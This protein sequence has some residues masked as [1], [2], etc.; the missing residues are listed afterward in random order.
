MNDR[1]PTSRVARGSKIGK[2]A[3]GQALRNAGTRASMLGRSDEAKARI[4][5][6]A[7]LQAADQLVTV[8]GSMKGAAMKIGQMLSVIDLDLVPESHREHFQR[9]LAVLRD[10]A[11]KVSFDAMRKIIEDDLGRSISDVF[12]EFDDVPIAAASIGQVYRAQLHDGRLVAVKVQYPGIDV[13]IR[14]DMKNLA[15]FLKFW[16]STI[17]TV[18]APELAREIKLN[19]ESELD[20]EREARTQH[21][22]AQLFAGHP[23]IEVP[24]SV[25][26]ASGRRV[27]VT[28]LFDGQPF[29]A[30][31]ALPQQDRDR[32][33]EIIYRFYI[34]SMFSYSEFCGD[35]HPGNILL[36]TDGK[37]GF[38]DFGLYNKMDPVHVDFEKQCLRAA[39]ENRSQDLFD[40]MVRRGVINADA[41]VSVDEC[42]DYV[43]GAAGWHLNDESIE[44]TPAMASGSMLLAIDPRISEFSG[45]RHQNLPPEHIFSRRAEFLTF[46]VL[47]Q[48][49]ATNNWHR[50]AREWV[51]D[52]PP[53][54]ALGI[55]HAEWDRSRTIDE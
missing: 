31:R 54:T 43:Y 9:K 32:V 46:G 22:L 23:F 25:P 16:R 4:S 8:L 55:A 13:A 24:D 18:A 1:V 51:Y 33:G 3:A 26:S 34:G 11:P 7:V 20:Y 17:P 19:M 14:A 41:G 42:L 39:S 45:M 50:I 5:E 15:M 29:D 49:G 44:I 53:Q 10:Q 48:L 28:E 38:I 36:G 27:V 47:G 40:L 2:A 21:Q 37:V 35:P 52:E 12:A 6:K 30:I